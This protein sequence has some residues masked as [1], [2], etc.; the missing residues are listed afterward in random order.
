MINLYIGSMQSVKI[1]HA[2]SFKSKWMVNLPEK[3]LKGIFM[4]MIIILT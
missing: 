4:F 1:N 2:Q 3:L